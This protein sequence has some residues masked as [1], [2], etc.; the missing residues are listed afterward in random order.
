MA[1]GNYSATLL[2]HEFTGSDRVPIWDLEPTQRVDVPI[3]LPHAAS[4]HRAT[5]AQVITDREPLYCNMQKERTASKKQYPR[6]RPETRYQSTMDGASKYLQ[7]VVL[8][9]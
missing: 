9:F 4:S 8:A 7:P 1:E 3:L 6:K 5:D 2:H